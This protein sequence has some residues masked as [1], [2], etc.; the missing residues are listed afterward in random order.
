MYEQLCKL[1][2]LLGAE[3][4]T[5]YFHSRRTNR[6][7]II[8]VPSNPRAFSLNPN[9]FGLETGHLLFSEGF[10]DELN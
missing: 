7:R 10:N 6:T 2:S 1:M 4:Q 9:R 8:Q 5:E 3:I